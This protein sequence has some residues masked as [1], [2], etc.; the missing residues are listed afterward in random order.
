[1]A[2]NTHEK[3]RWMTIAE[4]AEYLTVSERTVLRM[5][6]AGDLKRHKIGGSTRFIL[7]E[8]EELFTTS[9]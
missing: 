2:V 9:R 5:A 1:M 4:V 8:V 3:P 7:D 6:K